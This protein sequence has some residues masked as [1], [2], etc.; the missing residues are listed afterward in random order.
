MIKILFH[1]VDLV[2]NHLNSFIFILFLTYVLC[3]LFHHLLPKY[4]LPWSH[5]ISIIYTV[6]TCF[7]DWSASTF[8]GDRDQETVQITSN[9]WRA[10]ITLD[11]F[12]WEGG[13]GG[14]RS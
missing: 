8:G 1:I 4:Y 10:G 5:T 13:G 3:D 12:F 14:W 6:T 7:Q 9:G 2:G 11:K